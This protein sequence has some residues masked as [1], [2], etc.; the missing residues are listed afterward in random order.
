VLALAGCHSGPQRRID[1]VDPA[2]YAACD[3]VE[4]LA[5]WQRAQGWLAQGKDTDALPELVT[6]TARC[7]DLVRAH[8]AYQDCAKRLGGEAMRK[9]LAFYRQLADR[10]SPVPA[11][12]RA[13]LADTSYAQCNALEAIVQ[14]DPSFAWAH[15]SRARVTRRQGRL[16]QALDMFAAAIVNDPELSEARLERA[17]VLVDLGRG[18]EAALDFRRYLELAPTDVGAVRDYIALLLYRLDR[19]DEALE[20]LDYLERMGATDKGARMDRAAAL[21]RAR[22]FRE[23]FDGYLGVLREW[24]KE[25]RAAWNIGLILFE[26]VPQ[27]DAQRGRCW[28]VAR[29]AFCYFLEHSE[30]D[31]GHEQFERS[32]GVPFRLARIE[33][34]LGPQLATSATLDD[35]RWPE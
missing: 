4:A 28:P 34:R 30:S 9:M 26:S 33:E 27:D 5:A 18:E 23:A 19:T 13:R 3:D 21:W 12:L 16:Q 22:R 15:L 6:C 24:P 32:F 20:W 1:A 8:A 2:V 31:D 11:Y 17:Q 14:R 29:A 7:P 35:L 25:G 10:P